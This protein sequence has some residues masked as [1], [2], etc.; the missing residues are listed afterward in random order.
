[1]C[2][3]EVVTEPVAEFASNTTY[4]RIGETVDFFDL[5]QGAVTAWNWTFGGTQTPVSLVKFPTVVFDTVGCFKVTLT[6][7]N[8]GV[9]SQSEVKDCYIYV[10]YGVGINSLSENDFSI[11]PNPASEF[12]IIENDNASIEFVQ[13]F[14]LQGKMV[15]DYNLSTSRKNKI[16][17]SSL[18][19]GIYFLQWKRAGQIISKK[20]I[21][22]H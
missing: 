12:L 6:V 21:I 13:L 18:E 1:V 7:F 11:F 4:T 22:E 15:G 16:E 19:N 3:I 17:V 9:A 2:F 8:K 20:I 14:S 5:S 10:D